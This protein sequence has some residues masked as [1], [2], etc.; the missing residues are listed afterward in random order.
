[1]PLGPSAL[2]VPYVL[3]S[4]LYRLA[5]A[6]IILIDYNKLLLVWIKNNF[7]GHKGTSIDKTDSHEGP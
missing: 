5:G 1:M 2:S 7:I 4:F 6:N 3:I